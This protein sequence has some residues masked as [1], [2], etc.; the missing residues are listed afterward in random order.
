MNTYSSKALFHL[1]EK[2]FFG[3]DFGIQS[4][5]KIRL[6]TWSI[7]KAMPT[8]TSL[9]VTALNGLTAVYARKESEYDGNLLI[10]SNSTNSENPMYYKE[11][12][13]ENTGDPI[14]EASRE[15]ELLPLHTY[16]WFT[17][18]MK[19]PLTNLSWYIER[20]TI[21]GHAFVLCSIPVQSHTTKEFAIIHSG[22]SSIAINNFLAS[23][24]LKGGR[25]FISDQLGT[26][27]FSSDATA[28]VPQNKTQCEQAPVQVD[29]I[30]NEA[31]DFLDKEVGLKSLVENR[32]SFADVNIRNK[33]YS[34]DTWPYEFQA[35]R[36][37]VVIMI[38]RHSF[39]GPMDYYTRITWIT[40]PLLSIGVVFIGCSLI[41]L[42]VEQVQAEE[43]LRAEIQRQSEAKRRAEASRDAKTNFLSSM[44][45]ELRTPMACIIGLLDMLLSEKLLD[46]IANSV[47]Q[48]HRCATSLVAILNSALDIAKVESG[49]LVLEMAE[50]DLEAELTALIDVFSVQCDNKG[51]FICL[52]LA[53]DVP[54]NVV[55]DSARVMQVFTNLIGNSIKFT[56]CGRISVRAR[57]ATPEDGVNPTSSRLQRRGFSSFS[58]ETMFTDLR[59]SDEVIIL[60][61]VD[62]TGPGIEPTLRERVFENFV[63]GAASTTRTHGG[64]GL[65]LGI[66]KSL[67]QI[68]GGDIRIVEKEGQGS[69]FQFTICFQRSLKMEK[70]PFILPSSLEAAEVILGIPNADCRAVA[71]HWVKT[72]GLVAHEVQTWKEVLI[73]MRALNGISVDT[74][75]RTSN[76]T[77]RHHVDRVQPLIMD[78]DGIGKA[79]KSKTQKLSSR[80]DFWKSWQ[81]SG[82]KAFSGLQ[83]QLLII[84]ISLL[85]STVEHDC[86]EEYLRQSGFL[87]GNPT[88]CL[89]T[90]GLEKLHPND[91]QL[92]DTQRNLLVVWVT[93]SNTPEP[94]KTALRSV[95]NSI[96][97]RRP[98]HATRLKE[99]LHQIASEMG[100]S[101]PTMDAERPKILSSNAL[102]YAKQ[103]E[104]D[105]PYRCDTE[106][107]L[108][109]VPKP[110]GTMSLPNI[111]FDQA[112]RKHPTLSLLTSGTQ[113]QDASVSPRPKCTHRRTRTLNRKPEV[114]VG[115]VSKPFEN[116]EIL[117]AEDTPL[118]RRLAVVML[119]KLGAITYEAG[120]GQEVVD[121]VQDRIDNSKSPFNCILMDCQMPVMDGYEACK[122]VRSIEQEQQQKTPIIALT[123][124]AMAS[125]EHKCLHAGMDAFLTKPMNQDYMIEV[126]LQTV[127]S[128]ITQNAP[129]NSKMLDVHSAKV[130]KEVFPHEPDLRVL[131]T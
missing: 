3:S 74:D 88:A 57:L 104:W 119:Q 61:E 44:S 14:S 89:D 107:S 123:A 9:G 117:V 103:Q 56:S 67:V 101:L 47:R 36:L 34:V 23:L 97:V 58:L 73:H 76:L 70:I 69:V 1:M 7:F 95:R 72:W 25:I 17:D 105:D 26:T 114:P 121:A 38:P 46:D 115:A 82:T 42:L 40:L 93:A 129:F 49:K 10:F 84:D 13:D 50:F 30:L 106:V 85:P 53:D 6:A 11:F 22:H 77:H 15:T 98:L 35:L 81:S 28:C 60:F 5:E 51:L 118:L 87:T 110:E 75:V 126:I 43:K 27:L 63:Q 99:L 55:G 21:N 29:S 12:V 71:A 4:L 111:S 52:Q 113:S 33:R 83:R 20:H 92:L 109:G 45:H 48:I 37:A 130:S 96:A 31:K 66:V 128:Q 24:D 80:Y 122:A 32:T 127:A 2:N 94:V 64:T 90:L 41:Y 112:T 54:K 120:N 86:L 116:L 18:A 39:W 59:T 62:D 108:P 91:R 124:N 16:R 102:A 78:K 131:A 125:D 8:I 68:M 79:L 65:G 100:D 19:V